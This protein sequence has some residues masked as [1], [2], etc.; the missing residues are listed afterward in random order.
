[1]KSKSQI[2]ILRDE[3]VT[4]ALM[5]LAIPAILS[6]L[7]MTL[8]NVIDTIFIS[9]LKDNTMIAATTVALPH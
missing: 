5:H 9:Q 1:M 2:A 4:K 7:V 6:S 8:H 3:P